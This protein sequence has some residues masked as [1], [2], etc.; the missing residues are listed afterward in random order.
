M[1]SIYVDTSSLVKFYYP[2]ADSDNI[3]A[4]LLKADRIHISY[5]TVVEMASAMSKKVR[6][7]ELKKDME[8]VIWNT[9]LDD[10]Q[11]ATV[12]LIA[13][14]ERHYLKASDFIREFGGK[15]GIKTLDALQLSVAHSLRYSAFLC[16]D[17]ALSRLAAK[18]G[19]KLIRAA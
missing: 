6:M 7:N 18:I 16:S 14:E 1:L 10:I 11:T 15:Y 3:E 12:E 4:V 2:E 9:F 17:T 8:T 5:L 19:I 13:L